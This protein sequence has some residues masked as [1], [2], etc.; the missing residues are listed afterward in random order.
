MYGIIHKRVV[1]FNSHEK[2]VRLFGVINF[3][4]SRVL[5]IYKKKNYLYECCR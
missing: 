1:F 2:I 3:Y 4:V 5:F